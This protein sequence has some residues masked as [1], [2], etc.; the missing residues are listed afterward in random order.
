MD[1]RTSRRAEPEQV[2]EGS[3]RRRQGEAVATVRIVGR[4]RRLERQQQERRV[5][6]VAPRRLGP[7]ALDGTEQLHVVHVGETRRLGVEHA[8]A[9][10]TRADGKRL[11]AQPA[12]DGR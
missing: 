1:T 6:H 2:G 4:R 12:T 3:P 9:V 7:F 8:Q 11:G 5:E 10:V